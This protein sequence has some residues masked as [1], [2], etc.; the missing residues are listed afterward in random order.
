MLRIDQCENFSVAFTPDF[1]GTDTTARVQFN[2]CLDDTDTQSCAI[3][4]NVTLDG[5]AAT[6]TDAV[7]G[8]DATW[9]Y[10]KITVAAAAGANARIEFRCNQ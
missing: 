5:V 8:A 10:A 3:L 9:G 1:D 6:N 7:Y 4:E 2:V